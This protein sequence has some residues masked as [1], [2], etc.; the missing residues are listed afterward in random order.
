[1]TA[2]TIWH[3]DSFSPGKG[4]IIMN[5]SLLVAAVAAIPLVG[6]SANKCSSDQS[7]QQPPPAEQQQ[8]P[9]Q[10]QTAPQQ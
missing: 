2:E 3:P 9:Q 10:P 7:E 4:D 5:R 8:Q 6:L 1:L